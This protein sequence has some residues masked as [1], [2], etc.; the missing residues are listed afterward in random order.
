MGVEPSSRE[1]RL[2]HHLVN[3][4]RVIPLA[5]EDFAR[6]PENPRPRLLPVT[7]RVSHQPTPIE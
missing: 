3:P 1:P 2:F 7:G 6:R 5:A 4:R